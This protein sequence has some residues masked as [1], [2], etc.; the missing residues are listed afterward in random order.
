MSITTRPRVF[1][2]RFVAINFA[3]GVVTAHSDGIHSSAPIW[4]RFS[5]NAGGSDRPDA[6]HGGRLLV[7]SRVYF[8]WG[9]FVLGEK[10]LSPKMHWVSGIPCFRG[11]LALGILHHRHRRLDAESGRI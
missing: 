3:M 8:F 7:L 1:G 4:A 6:R 10:R 2:D 5:R 9:C 11:F